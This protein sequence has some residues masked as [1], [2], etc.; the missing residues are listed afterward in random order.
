MWYIIHNNCFKILE[1]WYKLNRRLDKIN[2]EPIPTYYHVWFYINY[3]N[4]NVLFSFLDLSSVFA[5]NQNAFKLAI[6]FVLSRLLRSTM[7][8]ENVGGKMRLIIFYLI[9]KNLSILIGWEQFNFFEIQ[10]QK[11]KYIANLTYY[12]IHPFIAEN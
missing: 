7:P 5:G 8:D 10:C 9:M 11:M 12:K 1:D 4:R 6:S 3:Y 2:Y